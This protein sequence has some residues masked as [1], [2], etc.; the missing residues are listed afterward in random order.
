MRVVK[1]MNIGEI[2]WAAV[3][4]TRAI[5]ERIPAELDRLWNGA[6]QGEAA[7]AALALHEML[8]YGSVEVVEATVPAVQILYAMLSDATFRWKGFAL[9]LIDS[10]ASVEGV[11]PVATNDLS[12]LEAR[13]GAEVVRGLPVVRA[14]NRDRDP[15]VQGAAIEL[16]ADLMEPNQALYDEFLARFNAES[17][18]ILKADLAYAVIHILISVRRSEEITG[19]A[20]R[21]E[22]FL[23]DAGPAV[24]YR[25]ARTLMGSSN[26]DESILS[27]VMSEAEPEVL[28]R[29]LYRLE[30]M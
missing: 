14:L 13:V 9:Q 19:A 2:D 25:A 7:S 8:C 11:L 3:A 12:S 28:S 15:E 30:Y 27:N 24:R 29:R 23:T 22:S 1:N 18:P 10:I 26:Y 5:G 6:D 17:D 4:D 21:I 20:D 16:L